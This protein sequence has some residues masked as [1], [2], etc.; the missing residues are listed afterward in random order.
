MAETRTRISICGK[1]YNIVSTDSKEHVHRVAMRLEDEMKTLSEEYAN[2]STL[3]LTTLA[4]LNITDQL[5][6]TGDSVKKTNDEV[7]SLREMLRELQIRKQVVDQPVSDERALRE[8]I[9]QL[10]YENARLK[11]EMGIRNI[12]AEII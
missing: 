8:R 2:I 5:V 1:E 6:K 3:M 12:N 4:A 11:E 9:R 10:E 7:E